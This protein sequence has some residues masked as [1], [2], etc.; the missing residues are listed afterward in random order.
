[1][2]SLDELIALLG[3]TV[4]PA[5]IP[6]PNVRVTLIGHSTAV[7]MRNVTLLNPRAFL[8]TIPNDT[9]PNPE[10]QVMAFARG[11]P[12]VELVA[13]DPSAG[14]VLRFF[15]IRFYLRCEQAGL[16][17]KPGDLLTASI[18]SGWTGYSIYDD[19]DVDNTQLN[20]TSCH[21]RPDG[22]KLLRMQELTEPWLHWFYVEHPPNLA[23]V[24]A[25]Q[26][27]HPDEWYGGI[28]PNLIRPQRPINMQRITANNGF[29]AQP[30][31]FDT[32]VIEAEIS[33]GGS[34]PTW[35]A[36]YARA[37]A[38][39]EIAVPYHSI[40]FE[41]AKIAAAVQIYAD[42]A[43]GALPRDQMPDVRDL[44]LDDALDEMSHRPKPGL[45]GRGI[46]RHMCRRCHN[47]AVDLTISRAEFNVD[48]LDELPR[49]EK[50]LA[51]MR[52]QLPETD[53][54][55]MPPARFHTLSDAERD[56]VIQELSR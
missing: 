39:D 11:E 47:D 53:A 7:G 35:D 38:G 24:D 19:G 21:R 1:L 18:E 12:F 44:F 22:S 13:N 43:S 17:C 51:I 14:G 20:C 48:R 52:L 2:T 23:M 36:R 54:R 8:M 30:N 9:A 6:T 42:V 49:S 29:A 37:V 25:F 50:D 28:P 46:M 26:R 34:S 16:R 27:A 15:L 33:A 41:S 4:D 3:L 56:L 10:F 32:R 5:T 31:V 55:H 40:P 45:D